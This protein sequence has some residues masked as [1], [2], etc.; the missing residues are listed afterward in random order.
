MTLFLL[1][2]KYIHGFGIIISQSIINQIF[3]LE[4]KMQNQ[5]LKKQLV[6]MVSKKKL[7]KNLNVEL[8]KNLICILYPKRKD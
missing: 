6:C 4:A 3:Y 5:L 7:Y 8:E 2:T 1:L